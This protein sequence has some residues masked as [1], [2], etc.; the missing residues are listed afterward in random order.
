MCVHEMVVA[1]STVEFSLGL[2]FRSINLGR[3][4]DASNCIG[5]EGQV[6]RTA[7]HSAI[8]SQET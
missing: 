1:V 2:H 4:V 8:F 7:F 5:N 6:P 3:A